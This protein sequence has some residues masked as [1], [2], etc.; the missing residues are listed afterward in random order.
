MFKVRLAG[1]HLYRKWLFTR[2]SLVISLMVSYFVL[3]FSYELS[4]MGSGTELSQFLRIFLPTFDLISYSLALQLD[5]TKD[6]DA[7][8]ITTCN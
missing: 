6:S 7:L 8:L 4:W 3:S 2:L 1:D 5:L